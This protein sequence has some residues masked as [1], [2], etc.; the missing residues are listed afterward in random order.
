MLQCMLEQPA[1]PVRFCQLQGCQQCCG[2]AEPG[3]SAG[4]AC[5]D[6]YDCIDKC[7][8]VGGKANL[9]PV[10]KNLLGPNPWEHNKLKYDFMLDSLVR[11]VRAYAIH[12]SR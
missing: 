3:L 10:C 2:V 11:K 7:I 4:V 8:L 1:H 5:A 12:P 9:C 6:C